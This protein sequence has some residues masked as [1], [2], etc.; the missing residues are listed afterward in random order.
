MSTAQTLTFTANGAGT[1]TAADAVTSLLASAAANTT[2]TGAGITVSQNASN[3][4]VFTNSAN[5]QFT[6]ESAG[7]TGNLLGLGAYA[8][9]TGS[10]TA[11]Y[12]SILAAANYDPTGTV[13][14]TGANPAPQTSLQFSVGGGPAVSIASIALDAGDA[15]A[16]KHTSAASVAAVSIAAGANSFHFAVDG[17]NVNV[18][19]T[20]DTPAS[21]ANITSGAVTFGNVSTGDQVQVS[22]NGTTHN[23]TLLG[24]GGSVGGAADTSVADVQ[25]DLQNAIDTAFGVSHATVTTDGTH[26]TITSATAGSGGSVAITNGLA[27]DGLAHLNFSNLQSSQGTDTTTSA[28]SVANQINSAIT[29]ANLTGGAAATASVLANGAIAITNSAVGADHTVSAIT[30]GTNLGANSLTGSLITALTVG[31]T[32][33]LGT[34]ISGTNLATVITGELNANATLAAAG[35]TASFGAGKLTISSSNNTAFRVNAGASAANGTSVGTVDL[36]SGANF[37]Q[38]PATLKIATVDAGVSASTT[39]TLN[40]NYATAGALVTAINT[41]L[42]AAGSTASASQVSI[43]GKNYLQIS[44]GT[45]GPSHSVQVLSTGTANATLGFTDNTVKA[46]NNEVN[47][48]FGVSNTSDVGNVGLAVGQSALS[49]VNAGGTTQTGALTFAALTPTTG[50]QA[51]TVAANNS[52]GAQQSLTITLAATGAGTAALSNSGSG[53]SID[54]AV[55][56]INSQLQKTNNSTLQSIVAVKQAVGGK[57]EINFVSPL[58][59]FQVG[60]GTAAPNTGLNAGAAET[61]TASLTGASSNISIETQAGAEAAITA[62]GN[63]VSALGSAQATV[64]IGENQLGYAV[65]LASSQVTNLSA[66]ESNIRD[67]NVAAQAANLS[68][69]Q[70]LQQASIAAMAQANS[71]PQAV[72]ALLRG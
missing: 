61:A 52:N 44:N 8:L 51:L 1:S 48:G 42:T 19:L 5:Q 67:A 25:G 60:V 33:T 20:A 57:E 71:A 28:A 62:I 14:T 35:L 68:K 39:V 55:A 64:G 13:V 2:L 69:A 17:Q 38:S 24:Y 46:G 43:N 12:T 9:K 34:N 27:Q 26:L 56:Y 11:D 4:L 30:A 41:Q 36:T 72:L 21:T 37:S 10:T 7:D 16:A 29:A 47:I 50:T 18:A 15:T 49:V 6:V 31:T 40:Q 65:S 58:A 45:A 23:V 66:A 54:N 70:V 22:I 32:A 63:A 59:A 3:Q 53:D